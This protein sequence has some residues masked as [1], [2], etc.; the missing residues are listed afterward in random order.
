MSS[1]RQCLDLP[2]YF[3]LSAFST[4][5]LYAILIPPVRTA[6]PAHLNPNRFITI[7]LC[8]FGDEKNYE[9]PHYGILFSLLLLP[10]T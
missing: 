7:I 1:F 5:V 8:V 10:Q 4:K 6:C 2:T 9:A 3:L